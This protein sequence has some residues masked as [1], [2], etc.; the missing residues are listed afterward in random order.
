MR[1]AFHLHSAQSY[2]GEGSPEDWARWAKAWNLDLLV[3]TEHEGASLEGLPS[4]VDGV[5]MLWTIER[6]N[7]RQHWV[8]LGGMRVLL[9]PGEPGE[10]EGEFDLWEAWNLK[11]DGA[12]PS[13]RALK[14]Y[15]WPFLGGSD[16]H[17]PE[18][19]P[20]VIEFVGDFIEALKSRR[21]V[22][23]RGRVVLYPDGRV[24]APRLG[25]AAHELGKTL[26][27]LAVKVA[28]KTGIAKVLRKWSARRR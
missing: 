15:P 3:F 20:V 10:P 26:Y 28:R 24:E 25:W 4:E 14:R 13:K 7:E 18:G 8:E 16:L 1:A 9:H 12:Y 21:F 6:E 5:R 17:R 22:V 11:R 27:R 2:D 23:K 19:E